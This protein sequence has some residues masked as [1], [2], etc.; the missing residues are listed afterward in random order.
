MASPNQSADT[1]RA[2][3]DGHEYHEA[4][5]ARISMQL[6]WPDSEL[7]AIAVEG[8]SVEDQKR[9]SA[10]TVQISDIALYYGGGSTFLGAS[11]ISIVQFKYSVAKQER[12]F[13]ASHAKNTI[14]KFSK[15]YKELKK[16]HGGQAV[17][18][19]LHFQI[20]GLSLCFRSHQMLIGLLRSR[21]GSWTVPG[22]VRELLYL[23]KLV[24]S[25]VRQ[26]E[27]PVFGPD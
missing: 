5:T 1:V 10:Q 21:H 11:R 9:A 8:L 19:K 14:Q 17:R 24:S 4:W 23:G 18:A 2:S 3:R 16:K 26:A 22:D 6:L 7:T 25:A 15:A 13:R 12:E 20:K 27:G